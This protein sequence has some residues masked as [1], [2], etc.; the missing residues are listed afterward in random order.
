MKSHV[1]YNHLQKTLSHNTTSSSSFDIFGNSKRNSNS[2][3]SMVTVP[4]SRMDRILMDSID[5]FINENHDDYIIYITITN[6]LWDLK[7]IIFS[8]FNNLQTFRILKDYTNYASHK[9]QVMQKDI[10]SNINSSINIDNELLTDELEKFVKKEKIIQPLPLGISF[11][12][13]KN[14]S[15]SNSNISGNN[16]LSHSHSHSHHAQTHRTR[17]S[18]SSNGN[19][20]NN[21]SFSNVNNNIA[22]RSNRSGPIVS[23]FSNLLGS[24]IM[25]D[26][27]DSLLE[28]NKFGN[29]GMFKEFL[30]ENT[31]LN[32]SSMQPSV[33][34]KIQ[35]RNI[36]LL[37]FKDFCY[38][39]DLNYLIHCCNI[40]AMENNGNS[41][42]GGIKFQDDDTH[43]VIAFNP[44][45]VLIKKRYIYQIF[46]LLNDLIGTDKNNLIAF[47]IYCTRFNSGVFN[48]AGS[49][50]SENETSR[51][52]SVEILNIVLKIFPRHQD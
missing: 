28:S 51:A 26:Y 39:L 42:I 21:D 11:E 13:Y 16:T 12:A 7:N 35:P 47:I 17:L 38:F 30:K 45:D 8:T 5:L 2:V 10:N 29:F 1:N 31:R 25:I 19:G 27:Y 9:L 23:Q 18:V 49:E 15:I 40:L 41:T 52:I 34:L 43:Q 32:S 4:I 37:G 44:Y 48:M 20:N 24:K 3:T 36:S 6:Y 33:L 14:S 22:K 46:R 50:N